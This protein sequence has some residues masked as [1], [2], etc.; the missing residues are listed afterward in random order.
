MPAKR[1]RRQPQRTCIGCRRVLTKRDLY[2]VV[3]TTDGRVVIDPTGKMPGRGS[4]VCDSRQCWLDAL[5]RKQFERA[6]KIELSAE[7]RAMIE[8]YAM[9]HMTAELPPDD[10]DAAR[11]AAR[12]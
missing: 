8:A 4:Y 5:A 3:R 10:P 9:E 1:S 12:E 11:E 2:R 7:D 6:L